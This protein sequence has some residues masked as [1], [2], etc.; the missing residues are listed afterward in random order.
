MTVLLT[1]L[2]RFIFTEQSIHEAYSLICDS[3]P[4]TTDKAGSFHKLPAFFFFPMGRG[5]R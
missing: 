3:G 2:L 5:F 1:V 4:G